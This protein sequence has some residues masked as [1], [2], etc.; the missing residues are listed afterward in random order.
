MYELKV[1][2][3]FAD[4]RIQYTWNAGC[5]KKM[6]DNEGKEASNFSN[7][8]N[9]FIQSCLGFFYSIKFLYVIQYIFVL[10]LLLLFVFLG[11]HPR[12]MEVPRLGDESHSHSNTGSKPCLQPTQLTVLLDP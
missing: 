4:V 3:R 6:K 10:L 9:K 11:P 12:H 7:V 1:L 8:I 2:G 5:M